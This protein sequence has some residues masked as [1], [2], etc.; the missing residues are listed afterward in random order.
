MYTTTTLLSVANDSV[1][2][3]SIAEASTELVILSQS[4]KTFSFQPTFVPIHFPEGNPIAQQAARRLWI[5]RPNA[6]A[7]ILFV[8]NLGI[9]YNY[10]IIFYEI[11]VTGFDGVTPA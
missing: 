11:G 4:G 2:P 10:S 8:Q 9:K 1:P 7:W 5:D 6:E 3:A